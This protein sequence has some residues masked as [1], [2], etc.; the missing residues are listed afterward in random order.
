MSHGAW[1]MR[2]RMRRSSASVTM[3]GTIAAPWSKMVMVKSSLARCGRRGKLSLPLT[4]ASPLFRPDTASENRVL[5]QGTGPQD[6][7]GVAQGWMH[8]ADGI[9]RGRRQPPCVEGGPGGIPAGAQGRPP[10]SH[11]CVAGRRRGGTV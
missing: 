7:G 4:G 1:P 10:G 11:A 3:S 6:A 8:R 5:M 9:A 2:S